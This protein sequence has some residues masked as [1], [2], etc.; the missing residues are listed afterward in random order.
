MLGYSIFFGFQGNNYQRDGSFF[1]FIV[2]YSEKIGYLV[3][4]DEISNGD[5]S[6]GI[7][8]PSQYLSSWRCFCLSV[9]PDEALKVILEAVAKRMLPSF[10]DKTSS[11]LL[12]FKKQEDGKEE[13]C[14]A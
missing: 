1:G 8:S 12:S 5:Q 2:D 4:A 13:V 10:P 9:T 7:Q 3:H 11:P 6:S 14:N